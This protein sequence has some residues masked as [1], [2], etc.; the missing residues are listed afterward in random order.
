MLLSEKEGS[1][2]IAKILKK[3]VYCEKEKGKQM[4]KEKFT[5]LFNRVKTF[6]KE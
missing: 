2:F 4:D 1:L 5:T 3:Y 6:L